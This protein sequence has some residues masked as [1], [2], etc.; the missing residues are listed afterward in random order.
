MPGNR[1]DNRQ[2]GNA[3]Q[4]LEKYKQLA[5]DA[6]QQGDRVQS[7]YYLQ[8]ADHYF[9]VLGESRAR[10]EDQRPRGRDEDY[11]EDDGDDEL[12]ADRQDNAREEEQDRRPPRREYREPRP[13]RDEQRPPREM[14]EPREAREPRSQP[15]REARE[16]R[17]TEGEGR[18]EGR[19]RRPRR[20]LNGDAPASEEARIAL[21]SLPPAIA[22]APAGMADEDEAPRPR[23][24]V[25]RPAAEDGDVTPEAA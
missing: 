10:Y 25:R 24:R 13:Q 2:R 12:G 8:F 21:D 16:P 11:D 14:R 4:L 18:F 5:R 22:A 6:Q 23:R 7:E 20:E 9:R 1:Q 17:G 15:Q 3:A 19:G